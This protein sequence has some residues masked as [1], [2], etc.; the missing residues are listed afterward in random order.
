MINPAIVALVQNA[1]LLLATVVVFDMATQGRRAA[2]LRWRQA[3]MGVFLGG[4]GIGLIITSY[5]FEPGIVFDSR[6]VLLGVAGLF[7]GGIPTA[8][9]V[10][11]TGLFRLWQGGEAS[12]VGTGVIISSGAIGYFWRRLRGRPLTDI[13]A[14]E[15]Y[16]FGV[17]VHLVMLAWMLGLPEASARRVLAAIGWPVM[18]IYPATTTALGLLLANRLRRE[19]AERSMRASEHRLRQAEHLAGLGSWERPPG[20]AAKE[21]ADEPMVWSDETYRILGHE[22]GAVRPTWQR[23]RERVRNEDRE[24]VERVSGEALRTGQVYRVEYRLA[25]PDRQERMVIEQAEPLPDPC[26]GRRWL[27]ALQNVTEARLAQERLR[28]LARAV[29]QSPVSIVITDRT[30]A[31][32]YVNPRF[33]RVTGYTAEEVL[34]KNPKILKSGEMSDEAYQTMWKAVLAGKEWRGEFHNRRKDGSMF[35][36]AAS[37]SPVRGPSG[38][39]T[40]LIAVKEDV[41]EKR[42]TESKLLRAQRLESIGSLASG[43]AHDLNNVLAPIVLCTP[44]LRNDLPREER[45]EWIATIETSV[46]RAVGVVRQLLGFARG[47][48]GPRIPTQVRHLIREI[49]DMARETF[50]RGIEVRVDCAAHLWPVVVDVTQIHQVLLNLCVNARDAMPSGGR[51]TLR[52]ENVTLDEPFVSVRP[53][54]SVG[55]HVRIRVEDTGTGIPEAMRHRIFETFFTTKA[56]GQGTGLGLTTVQGIVSD[57]GGF[58]EFTSVVGKGTTFEVHLPAQP[59]VVA[60]D[61]PAERAGEVARG[62][63]ETILVV[64][65]EPALLEITRRT[66]EQYGYEVA[67]ARDGIEALAQFAKRA[68]DMRAVV[69]DVMM[70]MMDGVTLVRAIRRIRPDTAVVVSSGGLF[71]GPGRQAFQALERLGVRHVLH[72]PHPPGELLRVLAE[73]LK[74]GGHAKGAR[75]TTAVSMQ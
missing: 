7:F 47:R 9:A 34:G 32:E 64:D 13:G 4:L 36:E 31:I 53:G 63:G 50:P 27:G 33:T 40:H 2:P 23:F 59:E 51:L 49:A 48:E 3:G 55:P 14:A 5:Q 6:S 24:E 45:E 30:G 15:L 71:D 11:V 52:A 46:G 19:L 26:G 20:P 8:V 28:N 38:E 74:Q 57:H 41:T 18:L 29:E 70:P 65:D 54:A 10:A 69:T 42:L 62:N 72:K 22:P 73:A 56:E 35:W 60:V 39:I 58:V 75:G 21:G 61:D 12:W 37:I 25:L 68:G 66:L 16:A 1:A 67:A 44:M 17:V 43:I